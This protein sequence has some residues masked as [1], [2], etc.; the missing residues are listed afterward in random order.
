MRAILAVSVALVICACATAGPG[1]ANPQPQA[2][3]T[4]GAALL[5]MRADDIK[6]AALEADR[7]ARLADAFRGHALQVVEGQAHGMESRGLH[8]EERNSARTLVS[9]DPRAHEAVL[10][11]AAQSR[12]V[13]PDQ[14]NPAWT[15][16][17]RQWWARL[18]YADGAWWVV[19]QA[20]LIPDQWRPV[21]TIG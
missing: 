12:L 14:P 10:Q 5:M 6:R 15:A 13:T 17:V 1:P 4:S 7:T 16:T 3:S 21:P 18:Q 11:I 9:W 8:V 19:E 20:D 2:L